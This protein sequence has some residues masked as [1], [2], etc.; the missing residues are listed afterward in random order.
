MPYDDPILGNQLRHLGAALGRKVVLRLIKRVQKYLLPMNII[1]R[2]TRQTHFQWNDD[3]E[4][5][6]RYF[7]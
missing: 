6:E 7:R 1:C 5:V 4:E 3:C 2:I